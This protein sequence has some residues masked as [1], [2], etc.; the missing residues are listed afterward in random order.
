MTT[1]LI[2]ALGVDGMRCSTVVDGAELRY[3]PP[4]SPYLK[5]IEMVF[6]QLQYVS[7]LEFLH[8]PGP[9]EPVWPE[10]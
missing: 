9:V 7:D 3:L 8:D 1:T 5:P 6:S 4:Y 10:P 2:A